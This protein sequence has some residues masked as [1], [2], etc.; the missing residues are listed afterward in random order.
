MLLKKKTNDRAGEKEDSKYTLIVNV[1]KGDS[2]EGASLMEGERVT[3]KGIV[4]AS[5]GMIRDDIL[6]VQD[7]TGGIEVYGKD[8]PYC[9]LGDEIEVDGKVTEYRGE[10]ELG[11]C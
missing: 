11:V 8:L 2:K 7:K 1:Q 3:V 6:Y 4:T 5:P 9:S 10:T